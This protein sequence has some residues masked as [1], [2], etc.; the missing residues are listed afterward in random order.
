[1]Q[2]TYETKLFGGLRLKHLGSSTRFVRAE[3]AV[4]GNY[5]GVL[6][7]FVTAA[8][9]FYEAQWEHMNLEEHHPAGGPFAS[10]KRRLG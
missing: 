9:E 5:P 4:Q 7:G 8:N 1:M 2:I 3:L 6:A 10:E